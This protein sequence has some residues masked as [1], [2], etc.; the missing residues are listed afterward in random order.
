M[1]IW[2]LSVKKLC[3]NHI[4]GEHRELHAIWNIISRNKKGYLNHPETKRWKGK[5]KTLY[6][7][8]EKLVVEMEKR[9]YNHNSPLDIDLA[10]RKEIQFEHINSIDDQ[11]KILKNKMCKCKL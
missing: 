4:L 10:V 5:L 7:R 1:R 2:D 8:H 6:N 9:G 11:I 3:K